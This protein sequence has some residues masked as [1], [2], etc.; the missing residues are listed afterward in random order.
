MRKLLSIFLVASL[1]VTMFSGC[2]GS[3]SPQNAPASAPSAAAP[4]PAVSTPAAAPAASAPTQQTG[5][6]SE[7]LRVGINADVADLAPY[8]S[9]SNGRNSIMFALYEYLG[10]LEHVGGEVKGQI[11]KEYSSDDGFVYDIVIYDYVHDTAG[12]PITAD[13]IVFSFETAK[14]KGNS[15]NTRRIE[16]IEKTGEYSV[17]LKINANYVGGFSSVLSAVPIVSIAAYEA[18]SD[19][20][21]A[22]PVATSPYKV[23]EF[24]PGSSV[25]LERTDNYWQKDASLQTVYATANSAK[26]TY[27]TIK[28]AAQMSIALET[29][30]IDMGLSLDAME[31]ARFMEGGNS[32][33]GFTVFEEITNIGNQ[34]YLS[35]NP[36]GPF[37][38]NLALREAVLYAIDKQGLVD[39]VLNGYGL[40]EYTFG[41][42]SFGDFQESWKNEDYFDYNP[43]KS[44]Q[45]LQEAGYKDGELTL[46]IMTDNT[47]LR[48]KVAQIVQSFLLNVGIKSEILQ[49]DSALFNSYK[50]TPTE[51]EICLDNTGASDYVVSAWRSKFDARQFDLGSTNG[52]KDDTMQALLEKALAFDGHTAEDVE[53]FHQYFKS[54]AYAMG[55]FN[56]TFF[57]V[58]VDS[59]NNI[60]YDSK[61]FVIAP[62]SEI[63]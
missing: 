51:W 54:Q 58:A 56:H 44:K 12:N 39:A 25:T 11:M 43:E 37:Y 35:G 38:D 21:A 17:R 48:N 36:D 34:I 14:E 27:T 50:T 26:I 22:T 53:A 55:L 49:Y 60:K 3:S 47:S 32:A 42:E 9:S 63:N 40:I 41:A 31:A 52:W 29:G 45:L 10:V 16:Q 57:T 18:S 19:E 7:H 33:N 5:G 62:A 20:M 28:E 23:S 15:T 13:D 24:V 6:V 4:A 59:I 30:N 8:S 2:G 1:T 46:R 61:M